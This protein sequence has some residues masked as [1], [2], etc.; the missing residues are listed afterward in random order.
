MNLDFR[1]GPDDQSQ[2][3]LNALEPRIVMP[4]H[5]H[6]ASSKIVVI[7]RGKICWIF[8]DDNGNETERV[9][10]MHMVGQGC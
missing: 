2:R 4:I 8:Y 10:W 1:N 7:L 3:M 9:H 6:Q 5:I